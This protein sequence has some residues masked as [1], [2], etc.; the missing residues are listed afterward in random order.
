MNNPFMRS[1]RLRPTRRAHRGGP[2]DL[3]G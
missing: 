2:H 1:D 3:S